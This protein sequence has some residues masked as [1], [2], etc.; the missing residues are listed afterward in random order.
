MTRNRPWSVWWD[1]RNEGDRVT[2]V[3]VQTNHPQY[4]HVDYIYR[5]PIAECANEFGH[6]DGWVQ[7]W[8]AKF[9][10]DITSGRISIHKVMRKLGYKEDV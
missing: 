1:F 2:H 10:S 4:T 8:F 3:V 6:V 7:D 5:F 9:E